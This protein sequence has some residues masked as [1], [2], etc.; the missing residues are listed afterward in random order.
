MSDMVNWWLVEN[1]GYFNDWRAL[2]FMI[3]IS[4]NDQCEY[5]NTVDHICSACHQND[6]TGL[7]IMGNNFDSF[8]DKSLNV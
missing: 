8:I 6:D 5:E 1:L 7:M 4:E 2:Y 3:K